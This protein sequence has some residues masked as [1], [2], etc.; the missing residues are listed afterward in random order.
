MTFQVVYLTGAPAAGK[1]SLAGRLR[2]MVSPLE[3]WEFG[4]RLTAYLRT[5]SGGG[6]E[7]AD[8]RRH[9]SRVISPEAVAAVDAQ[10]LEFVESARQR[11]HVIVDS[12]PVTKERYG[13]RVTP[14]SLAQFARLSP[15]QIWMLYTDPTV[16]LDR[17][18]ANA[19]GRPTISLEEARFHTFM[20]ASVATTYGMS[21][22][23]PVHLFDSNRDLDALAA[24]LARR[25]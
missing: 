10:L 16:A 13:Y 1:S 15:T 5:T 24:E 3:V 9:S 18:T 21:L 14:Y 8:L 22:G 19:Q 2:Q 25:F 7:Q 23:V 12:H 20:Q 11:A 6:L 17:I 4:E